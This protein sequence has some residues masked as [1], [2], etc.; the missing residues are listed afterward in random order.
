MTMRSFRV[1]LGVLL[2]AAHIFAQALTLRGLVTDESGAVVPTATVSLAG[3]AGLSK[4]AVTANDGSYS[5][6]GLPVGAYTVEAQ[7]CL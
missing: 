3:P 1:S 2:V 7:L 6:I 5:F 4:T